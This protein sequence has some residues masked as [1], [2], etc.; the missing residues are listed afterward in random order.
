MRN[1]NV[2][3]HTDDSKDVTLEIRVEE[4]RAPEKGVGPCRLELLYSRHQMREQVRGLSKIE[5]HVRA[6][7]AI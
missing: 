7:R 6:R 5:L 2:V 3:R 1:K 4:T